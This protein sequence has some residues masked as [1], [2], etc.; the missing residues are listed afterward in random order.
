MHTHILVL[1]Y[2]HTCTSVTCCGGTDR[3]DVT[4]ARKTEN[5]VV[6]LPL[7]VSKTVISEV[8]VVLYASK[9]IVMLL[10]Y[11]SKTAKSLTCCG[12]SNASMVVSPT[13]NGLGFRVQLSFRYCLASV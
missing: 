12:G 2:I 3:S 10:L 11:V 5:F 1:L 13:V 8:T 7:Y 6:M 9:T 4:T